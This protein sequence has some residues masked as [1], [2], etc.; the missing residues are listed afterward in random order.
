METQSPDFESIKHI[1]PYQAEYWSA[2]DLAPL[3]GYNKWQN[4]EV[5]I[6][7]AMTSCK[8]IGQNVTDHFTGV[9]KM[10]RLGSDAEREVKD[11]LLSRFACYLIAQNG[12]PRKKEIAEAQ[13]Y[14]AISTRK[15]ELAQLLENQEERIKLRERVT[16]NNK[17]LA[18]AASQAGVLSQNFGVF[19]NAGYKGLYG[20]L[21]VEEIKEHKQI[22]QRED[23]LDRMGRA[24][25]AANDF[26]ITQT[27]ERLRREDTIGQTNAMGV[28]HE[29]GEKVR[30]AIQ[31]IGGT[32][33]ED[34]PPEPS[35]KPLLDAKH[36]K[37]KKLPS[38]SNLDD[39]ISSVQPQDTLWE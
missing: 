7:R 18:Q 19:Q 31:D 22:N 27:E 4:F 25:L 12:D 21:G 11:Y 29:V 37:R 15:Q 38:Q 24:E 28:H 13:A 6:Q 2:R 39:T 10:V 3:L 17:A 8:Q 30:N 35:I 20:E 16:E 5:A 14:F 1:S 9:S 32:M 23:L 34:L 36:R 33:P 26:R